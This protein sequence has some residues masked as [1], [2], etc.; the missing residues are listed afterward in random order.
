MPKIADQLG[1]INANV[2]ALVAELRKQREQAQ[3]LDQ[4]AP[5]PAA[6]T[7]RR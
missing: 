7:P 4:T 5:T 6:D 3:E 2:E 1:R